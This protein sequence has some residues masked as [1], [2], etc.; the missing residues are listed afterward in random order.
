LF[1][2]KLAAATCHRECEFPVPSRASTHL[3]PALFYT[4]FLKK[5]HLLS[6]KKTRRASG[7]AGLAWKKV[8][9]KPTA[10]KA[11][12]ATR[13]RETKITSKACQHHQAENT[14]I[15]IIFLIGRT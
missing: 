2:R 9:R 15:L 1:E 11:T 8:C 5:T 7:T 13:A 6:L 14:D 12:R 10:S 4:N 3:P